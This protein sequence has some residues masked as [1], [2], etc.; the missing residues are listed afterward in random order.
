MSN[1]MNEIQIKRL[2]ACKRYWNDAP[3]HIWD[4][5]E[6]RRRAISGHAFAY[7]HPDGLL[8]R[9]VNGY[10]F[11]YYPTPEWFINYPSE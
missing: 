3:P 11:R 6:I 7:H 2:R 10:Y 1:S 8:Q 4:R 5:P 9:T